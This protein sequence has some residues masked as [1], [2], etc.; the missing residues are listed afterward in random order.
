MLNNETDDKK[1]LFDLISEDSGEALNEI[2]ELE[3]TEILGDDEVPR[4]DK[5]SGGLSYL[6]GV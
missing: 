5:A 6:M 4:D 3:E 1:D 2:K